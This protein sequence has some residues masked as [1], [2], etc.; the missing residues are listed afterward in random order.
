[1]QKF[2]V[3]LEDAFAEEIEFLT[4]KGWMTLDDRALSLTP[5]GALFTAGVIPLF[6]APS[7][8]RYLLEREP[9]NADDLPRNRR[10]ALEVAGD[11]G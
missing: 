5:E 6:Y 10:R 1:V 9:E 2:G 11:R 8:Q 7:A 3:R 4:R